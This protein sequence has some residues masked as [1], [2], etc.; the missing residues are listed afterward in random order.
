MKAL[1]IIFLSF[2]AFSQTVITTG[3]LDNPCDFVQGQNNFAQDFGGFC[4]YEKAN[5]ALPE[6]TV[7]RVI[8]FGDSITEFWKK[9]IPGIDPQDTLNRGYSGQ[10]TSQ[11]VI[12]FRA[13]V[14]NLKP[15]IVHLMAGT[16]DIAGNTGPTTL[17]RMKNNF[18][19]MGDLAKANGIRVVIGSILPAKAFSWR[20]GIRPAETIRTFNTWLKSYAK[21]NGFTYVD[22]HSALTDAEGGLS[23][24][25]AKDGVHPTRAGYEVM[26]RLAQQ[27]IQ[28]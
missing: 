23:E 5:Q 10:T 6:A 28:K 22:Y 7:N 3:V 16:N 17:E 9:D 8:Y 4:K 2:S 13:D 11:M 27:A 15:K 12:R 19:S 26:I 20:A 1:L 24:E 18:R 25:Y 21:E 14:I